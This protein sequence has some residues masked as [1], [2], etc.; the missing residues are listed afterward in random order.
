MSDIQSKI[1]ARRALLA[2]QQNAQRDEELAAVQQREN[3]AREEE[4][5]AFETLA[6]EISTSTT[7]V[8]HDGSALSIVSKPLVS[9]DFVD[10]K[11]T[12]ISVL[13]KKESRKRWTPFENWVV[14]GSISGGLVLLSYS[15]Y[16]SVV[17]VFGFLMGKLF[18]SEHRSDVIDD[19]PDIFSEYLSIE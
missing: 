9:S 15:Y 4:K 3:A 2:K 17:I 16:F 6:A 10:L 14:I 18:T 5:V 1:A 11:T 19:N 12:Q 13:L 7:T 8:K